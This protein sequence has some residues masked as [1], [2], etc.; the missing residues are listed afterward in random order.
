[1][2]KVLDFLQIEEASSVESIEQTYEAEDKIQNLVGLGGLASEVKTF[3]EALEILNF[4]GEQRGVS[5]KCGKNHNFGAKVLR[6]KRIIC[7]KRVR[8]K[9]QNVPRVSRAEHKD[10]LQRPLISNL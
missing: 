8:N 3:E 6:D 2:V 1:L 9:F 5:F 4:E 7:N 10:S